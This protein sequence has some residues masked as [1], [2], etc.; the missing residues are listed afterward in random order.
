MCEVF[1]LYIS[2]IILAMKIGILGSGDVG[3]ALATAFASEGH[4]VMIATRDPQS[5]KASELQMQGLKVGTFA[6]TAEFAEVAVLATLWTATEEAIALVEPGNLA[7]KVVIDVTNPLDFSAGMPP[8]LAVS[9]DDSGGERVQAWLTDSKVVKAL[10]TV[11]NEQMYKP[12]FGDVTP[13]MFDCGNDTGAKEVVKTLLFE[14]GW[15]PSDVGDITGSRQLEQLCILW[16]KV[17]MQSG[18]WANAFTLLTQ[19]P[20]K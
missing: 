9:G 19:P 6:D 15:Q 7:G 4:E 3:K 10:N 13:T 17:G 14:L 2:C 1:N 20:A 5:A 11:G 8:R 12:N 18:N 16:V